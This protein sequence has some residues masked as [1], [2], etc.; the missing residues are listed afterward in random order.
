MS[1][2]P[3]IRTLTEFAGKFVDDLPE[4]TQEMVEAY[5]KQYYNRFL[6]SES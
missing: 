2:F 3:F 4:N 6:P 1:S 5:T